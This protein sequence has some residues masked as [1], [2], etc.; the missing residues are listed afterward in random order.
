MAT[1]GLDRMMLWTDLEGRT[2]HGRWLLGHLVRPEGRTA[3]FEATDMEGHPLMVSI[4]EA[5]NDED[6]LLER[7]RAA[8]DVLHPNVVAIR[9][10]CIAH[11]DDT[12]VVVAAMDLTEENLADV[13][14]ER[15][16]NA[17]E[18]RQV[19]DAAL[20]GLAAMHARGLVHGRME[21]ASI[22]AI[23]NT[24][25]LRSDCIHPGGAEFASGAA[26]DV[27]GLG[28]VVTQAMTQRTAANENDPV[29][30]LL[31]EPMGR[32]VRRA[33]SGNARAT[34]VA[35]L[36][37]TRLGAVTEA[38]RES[39]RETMRQ[40]GN[41][42]GRIEPYSR[43]GIKVAAVPEPAAP[44]TEK[45]AG[46]PPASLPAAVAERD[47]TARVVSMRVA[48]ER[49]ETGRGGQPMAAT[50]TDGAIPMPATLPNPREM[51]K[52]VEIPWESPL[53][54]EDDAKGK[55]R[56]RSAPYV[57]LAAAAVVLVTVFTLY[58]ILHHESAVRTATAH[59]VAPVAAIPPK[60]VVQPAPVDKLRAAAGPGWRVVAYT[61]NRE[62]AARHRAEELAQRHPE[63]EPA[64][65]Q[66]RSGSPWLVT[67]G[68]VMSRT[69]A[70]ALRARALTM[71]FP[72]DTYA[73]NY[74]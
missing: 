33:L 7:F 16:L 13:L 63:L 41:E 70:V 28:R 44:I 74:H 29:L 23:G 9:D 71:G 56:R 50:A 40:A 2:L 24:V 32:A 6:E 64:V 69:D 54:L 1:A 38:A 57:M 48:A 37:G 49:A 73:R 58:G 59:A 5:L 66:P 60:V 4:T 21:A 61:Y 18:T 8:A 67:L 65:F 43:S 36:A 51:Q 72:A 14:R 62:E 42:G 34:E 19:L 39:V 55:H 31:P 46:D 68:G 52:Q 10:S 17:V 22:L 35:A 47:A 15:T 53:T 20:A 25:Q 12:P 27:R 3:W 45:E 11:I 30:Q 26:E